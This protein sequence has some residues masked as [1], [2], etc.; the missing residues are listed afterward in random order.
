MSIIRIKFIKGNEVKFISHLDMMNTFQRAIRRAGLE[1]EYSKGFNPQ[2][3]M[4]FGAPLSLGF[5]SEA[6]YADL[7]FVKDY[8]P[9]TIMEKLGAEL[10]SGLDLQEAAVR[11]S[12]KNIMADISF[13][14]YTFVIKGL[15]DLNDVGKSI[16]DCDEL[17]VEKTRN[18]KTRKINIKPLILEF[19]TAGSKGRLLAVAGNSG[20]LNP[21][22][23]S[24]AMSI[25]YD[26]NIE[27]TDINRSRQFVERNGV[28]MNP[29]A[30]EAM[31][32][33]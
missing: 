9:E 29:L 7:S 13:A 19:E 16:M 6:E 33:K 20:N 24:E 10:P 1:S 15:E 11:K 2:M 30:K 5:T 17:M 12:N 8:E 23:L 4:V 32:T 21:R 3:Q 14:E 22:L 31:E 25:K 28:K 18:G 27:F 26:R